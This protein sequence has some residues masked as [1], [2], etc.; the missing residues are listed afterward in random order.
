[1]HG[2][3]EAV[4][5]PGEI[6]ILHDLEY[7]ETPLSMDVPEGRIMG[8]MRVWRSSTRVISKGADCRDAEGSAKVSR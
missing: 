4:I 3:G 7:G 6:T 1:L 8:Q 5:S 2:K